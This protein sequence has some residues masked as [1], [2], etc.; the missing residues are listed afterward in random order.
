MCL[1]RQNAIKIRG[2]LDI[3]IHIGAEDVLYCDSEILR[4]YLEALG[5]PHTYRVF[6]G[7]AHELDKIAVYRP[8]E[9]YCV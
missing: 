7:A 8:M 1:V 6:H 5:I 3:N 4:M 9:T 2:G